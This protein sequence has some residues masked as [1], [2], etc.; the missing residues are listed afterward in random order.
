MIP[1]LHISDESADQ[2]WRRATRYV[3][4]NGSMIQSRAGLTREILHCV[5]MIRSPKERIIFSRPMNL[6]FA[7][8]ELIWTL[9]GSD[10]LD[11][12]TAWNPRMR[13][14]SDDA[15][16]LH[17]AYGPR[18]RRRFGLD[19]LR[20]AAAEL[21]ARPESRQVILQI[22]DGGSDFPA[23]G[24][25][26]KDV[27]CSIVDH[28]IVRDGALHWL[29][30]MRANDLF[31]GAPYDIFLFTCLQEVVAGWIGV[32][33]GIYTH[34]VGSLHIYER[35]FSEA[36]ELELTADVVG[37]HN[38]QSLAIPEDA[39]ALTL[40]V[41]WKSLIHLPEVKDVSEIISTARPVMREITHSAYRDIYIVLVSDLLCRRGGLTEGKA[42]SEEI[43]G[44]SFRQCHGKWLKHRYQVD[45]DQPSREDTSLSHSVNSDL[46][47]RTAEHFHKRNGATGDASRTVLNRVMLNLLPRHDEPLAVLDGGCGTGSFSRFLA[48]ETAYQV[49]GCDSSERTLEIAASAEP[50]LVYVKAQLDSLPFADESFDIVTL[51]FVLT[52]LEDVSAVLGELYRILKPAGK[53]V[54]SL[55]H[56]ASSLDVVSHARRRIENR[57]PTYLP[58][59]TSNYFKETEGLY[60]WSESLATRVYHRPIQYYFNAF[61]AASFSIDALLEPTDQL[62]PVDGPRSNVP[63]YPRFI[64]FGATKA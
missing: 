13:R 27:P 55:V 39:F 32:D 43:E 5:L 4:K 57:S 22:W 52:D 16:S 62:D 41:I 23:G 46:W 49:T 64:V 50:R 19:Q 29:H 44:L 14:F 34:T 17:G 60:Y 1:P 48:Q 8:A 61:R 12:L 11:F 24:P 63:I 18:L 40:G 53:L 2:V 3:Y 6:A 10:R 15:T 47:N 26:S 9:S 28:L 31:W 45:D 7:C 56:P 38:S 54:A 33:C 37:S 42:L 30:L 35:H 25:R 20:S 21:R 58:F 59:T 51:N 36:E